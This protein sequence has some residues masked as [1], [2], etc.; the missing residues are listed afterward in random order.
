M[1]RTKCRT[2]PTA[3]HPWFAW[4]PVK[5]T[6]VSHVRICTTWVWGE[7][8]WRRWTYGWA[9]ASWEYSFTKPEKTN[10]EI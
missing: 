1:R 8:V 5:E 4:R 2:N 10:W 3:W 6:T 9:D 7:W